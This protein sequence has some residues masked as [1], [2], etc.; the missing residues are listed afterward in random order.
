[1]L[2]ILDILPSD[3]GQNFETMILK[4]T[5]QAF[6]IAKSHTTAYHS[7]G[8]GMVE[9]SCYNTSNFMLTRSLQIGSVISLA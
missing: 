6:G 7:Q 2:C 4:E 8:D 1:M 5:L 9:R 3:Q